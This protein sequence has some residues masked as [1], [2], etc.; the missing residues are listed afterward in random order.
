MC[1]LLC[2]LN[3]VGLSSKPLCVSFPI[4][5][6]RFQKVDFYTDNKS[7]AMMMSSYLQGLAAPFATGF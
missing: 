6:L 2:A 5:L 4:V 1:Y 7:K 3:V